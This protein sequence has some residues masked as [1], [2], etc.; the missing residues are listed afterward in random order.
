M[1]IVILGWLGFKETF[2][3]QFLI[4]ISSNSGDSK[5]RDGGG[6]F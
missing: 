4:H 6:L 5:D 1:R 2:L 3:E